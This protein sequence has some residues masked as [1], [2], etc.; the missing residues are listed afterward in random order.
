VLDWILIDCAKLFEVHSIAFRTLPHP[1]GTCRLRRQ[2]TLCY[3]DE[4]LLDIRHNHLD[5]W[6]RM[7]LCCSGIFKHSLLF[8]LE[9]YQGTFLCS[10]LLFGVYLIGLSFSDWGFLIEWLL[11]SPTFISSLGCH[12]QNML[13]FSKW[14]IIISNSCVIVVNNDAEAVSTWCIQW[15]FI[16]HTFV[17]SRCT[18]KMILWK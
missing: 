14:S 8:Q 2:R 6:V 15:D 3:D 10:D 4:L 17:S 11:C 7:H 1:C 12:R 5:A 13:L 16:L 18:L 9:Y